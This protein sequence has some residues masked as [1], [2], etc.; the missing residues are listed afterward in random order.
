MHYMYTSRPQK[1]IGL[2]GTKEQ[3]GKVVRT[4]KGRKFEAPKREVLRI[5]G[6]GTAERKVHYKRTSPRKKCVEWN[7]KRYYVHP[8]VI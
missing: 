3:V 1:G 7:G 5:T 6:T 4:A 8:D 2:P